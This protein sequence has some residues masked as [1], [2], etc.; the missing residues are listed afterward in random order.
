MSLII[1]CL[2]SFIRIFGGLI[3]KAAVTLAL[4]SCLLVPN[5]STHH[6][7]SELADVTDQATT[8]KLA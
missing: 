8:P 6:L 1:Y 4:E 7:S 5:L 2:Y 3:Y